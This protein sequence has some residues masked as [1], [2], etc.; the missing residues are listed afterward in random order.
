MTDRDNPLYAGT[1]TADLYLSAFKT[2]PDRIALVAGKEQLTYKALEAKCYQIARLLLS[3]G[4]KTTPKLPIPAVRP[5]APKAF[6]TTIAPRS[7]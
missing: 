4:L 2:Y 3:K 1:T 7:Q 6:C 5:D